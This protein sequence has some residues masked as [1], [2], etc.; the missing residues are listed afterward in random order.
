[1]AIVTLA[2]G[3][4]RIPTLGDYINSFAFTEADGSVTLV[5]CGIKRAPKTIVKALA[6]M[7]K[8]PHDVQRIVLT[9]A[10]GDHAGGAAEL[11]ERTGVSGVTAHAD[12]IEF[13]T[14]GIAAPAHPGSPVM[15]VYVRVVGGGFAPVAVADSI[16]DGEILPVA[17]GVRVLHTP[18]HTPGHVSLLHETTGV[19]ITGDAIFN[20]G[21]RMKWPVAAFCTSPGLNARSAQVFADLDY[22]IAAFTHGP[23]IRDNAREQVRGFLTRMRDGKSR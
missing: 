5:D 4:H 11:L 2:P 17:G 19:L 9:H 1:M 14:A 3:V 16:A 6:H 22:R 7:G 20:M 23:E 13:L 8:H 12:D 18:G 10:H 15:R 21:S